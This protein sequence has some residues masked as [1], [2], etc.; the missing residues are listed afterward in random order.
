MLHGYV[1]EFWGVSCWVGEDMG[2]SEDRIEPDNI[3]DH[4]TKNEVKWVYLQEGGLLLFM[5]G[6]EGYDEHVSL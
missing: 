3:E 1:D 4:I 6:I 2:A 5:E